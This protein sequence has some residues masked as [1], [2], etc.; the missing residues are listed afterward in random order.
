MATPG[1]T[2]LLL[3]GMTVRK[4]SMIVTG[5]FKTQLSGQNSERVKKTCGMFYSV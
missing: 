5:L 4:L 2:T 3:V 1:I